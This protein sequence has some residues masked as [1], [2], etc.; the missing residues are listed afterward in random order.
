MIKKK[1]NTILVLGGTGFIGYHL[2]KK[3]LKLGWISFSA[4]RKKPIKNRYLK[5]VK[6]IKLDFKKLENLKVRDYDFIVN[7]SNIHYSKAFTLI[8]F[9]K[10]IKIQKYL[11]VG[12]SAEYGNINKVLDENTKCKPISLYGKNKLKITNNALKTFKKYSFPVIVVRLFQV[13]G[14]FDNKNKIIPFVIN[15]CLKNKRFNLTE[16]FQT[17]DF[18]HINDVVNAVIKLLTSKNKKV[19]GKIFNIGFGRSIS[20]KRLVEK[21]KRKIGKGL[22][23]FGKK[24]ISN[25]EIIHSK[26]SIKKIKQYIKWSPKINLDDGIN[27]LIKHER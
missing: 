12:S 26:S 9:F 24:K 4:S 23:V 17:R 1:R 6:Y 21:I 3:T 8:N 16:G 27:S 7:L 20:I 18:C 15:N 5:K 14:L 2:L 25:Q 10:K 11:E 19:T 13:Y 22:P